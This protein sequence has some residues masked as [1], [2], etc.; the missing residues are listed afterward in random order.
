MS[1][2]LIVG[3]TPE[4]DREILKL[5]SVL[6]D[7][8]LLKR[9]YYS[10]Y[11]P[12]NDDKNLPAIINKPPLLREHRLYQADWLLRFYGFGYEE[13]VTENKP[14]LDE[15]LDPKTF[16]ALNNLHLFPIEINRASKEE[17]IR[18]PGIGV[19]GANKIIK[20]RRFK[21]LKL[22]DLVALRISVKRAK[23][24]IL[25]DGRFQKEIPLYEEHIKKALLTPPNQKPQQLNLFDISG[26]TGEL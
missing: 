12:V 21:R 26:I 18:I 17:L 7:K 13:I 20:A 16:W 11:I 8:A 2:Q 19:R 22:E 4:S 15:E 3:A 9:V 25:C 6:Y 14:N 5:S 10:A 23:Y 1:T 24:F